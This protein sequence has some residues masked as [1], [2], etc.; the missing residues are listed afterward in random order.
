MASENTDFALGGVSGFQFSHLYEPSRLKD[1]YLEFWRQAEASSPGVQARFELLKN[2]T[3][4]PPEES[5]VLIDV[6]RLYGDF[7]AR[8][9]QITSEVGRIKQATLDLDPTFRFK[10]EFLKIRV[11]KRLDEPA[12]ANAEFAQLD[13][14]VQ[15]LLKLDGSDTAQDEEVRFAKLALFLL[16]SSKKLKKEPLTASETSRCQN[17]C[18]AVSGSAL[19]E[20]I[21]IVLG[22]LE[23]WCVQIQATPERRKRI[24]NWGSYVRP[25]KLDFDRLVPT[26]QPD[27]HLPE[28]LE[29][30]QTH[31]RDGFKLTDTRMTV[32]QVLR[33]IDYCLY[34]HQRE[35][36][37][38]SK[39]FREKEGG[40]K[41]N[42]LGISLQGCPLDERISEM[43]FLR[44]S[45][46]LIAALAM[47]VL[48]NPMCPGTGH[49]ICN[50]C[51]K[52]CI[53]QKQDP[54]N[55]PENE[56][57]ILTEVLKL[58]YGF[59]IYGLLTRLNPLNQTRPFALPYNGR[60]VLVVG[61]GPAGYTLS[62]YL[63][64]DG[65]GVMGIDALKLEPL[66][67]LLTGSGRTFPKPIK[68]YSELTKDL[69]TRVLMGFGGVSEYG[70]TVRWDKNFLVLIYLT[71]LRRQNLRFYGGIRFGGTLSLEDAW[72]LGLDHVAIATGAGRPTLVDMKNNLSRG[73]RKASDFLMSLQLTG[74]FKKSS[75]SNLQ[76]RLPALVIGGG[77]T[78][79]D[80]ATETLAY[81]PVQ[82]E[83]I[84]AQ[85]EALSRTVGEEA[86]WQMCD[87][88]EKSVLSVFL[89]HA[90]AIREE[91]R[92]AERQKRKPDFIPLLR[93]WGGVHVVYRKS[94][95]DSPAYRLNHEEV[96]KA[97]EEG[98][99]FIGHLTPVEV[100]KDSFG[101]AQALICK[102]SDG[103]AVRLAAR[104]IAV[105]AGTKPNTVYEKEY[106][107][108]FA[109]D[110]QGK[111]F[112]KH[113]LIPSGSGWQLRE[114]S[115][116]E[117]RAFFLSYEKDG[118]YVS[119]YGDNHPDYAG[120]VVKAMASAKHGAP[121][122]ARL[123]ATD[124]SA[125]EHGTPAKAIFSDL[126]QKLDEALL[127]K[128]V[129]VN[130]L[131]SNIVEVIVQG[132]YAARKF[133]PG[134]FYR[135]QNYEKEAHA[136]DGYRLTMEGLA[137][138][139]AWVDKEKDLLSLIVLEMGASSKLCALLSAG[140]PVIVMGPT[141]APSE[142]PK[143]ETVCLVGGGLGNAVLL[144]ISRA[145]K[146]NGCRVLY[147]A[148][149][150]RK[151]D[152]FL[153]SE[154]EA[155]TDQMVWSV[156][157]GEVIQTNRPQ[158][159]AFQGNIVQAMNAYA[160][161][162][163]HE[164]PMFSFSSIDRIL[165]IGSDR[166]MAAV[167]ASRHS[168]LKPFLNPNHRAI[169]SINSPMQCMMKEVCA[170]CLQRHVD[171]KTGKES[172]VF[173]CF[174]QDQELD[175]VD[176]GNLRDRLQSNS[177]AEKLTHHLVNGFL[178]K[179]QEVERA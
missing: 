100:E 99:G 41:K 72:E 23:V 22:Q 167:K 9:F 158:D 114:A 154:I 146:A 64:N 5:E 125:A 1:L 91:R 108:T 120:N 177:L 40:F 70:I 25:A 129:R 139:G 162:E 147:F 116:G 172:F 50:D 130:R 132:K 137:L 142:I 69:D 26:L 74:A 55:I 88:E 19:D 12:I 63:A 135:L 86:V 102:K 143:D 141:G 140:E 178:H 144:S 20:K 42:P 171:P 123:F 79:L 81:Y 49:R 31:P 82:V 71:L 52:G 101:S 56:T 112:K 95:E 163:F 149:Y 131:T 173:S 48:D 98:I 156:D 159:L 21:D 65:F 117:K 168:S 4:R 121:E 36:D 38:C 53:F 57:G 115:A 109:L 94:L 160:K 92:L 133:E 166:M 11:F 78:A 8:L 67:S 10:N 39:G 84:L 128:V 151:E 107:G 150:R 122:V 175:E 32:K 113:T 43:H 54:V 61:L 169:G 17:L 16:D 105:A 34:C 157:E 161:G 76:V 14:Q 148:G 119:F 97:L 85:F 66:D 179:S 176:F 60:N 46:D 126:V 90:Q 73:V 136:V 68:N 103:S 51:M 45:G 13:R 155:C 59:E 164:P 80:T 28:R 30:P 58:P 165:A 24:A 93:G 44:K 75:L 111:F 77:L 127:T 62:H 3:L 104:S 134:Q 2:S 7:V 110:A 18:A 27:P 170:Q 6:A 83:K 145:L 29:S 106:P 35:K 15:N 124:I 87:A 152:L 96:R 33:E 118:R 47:I 138:T 37:S 153:Q 89:E 174:N